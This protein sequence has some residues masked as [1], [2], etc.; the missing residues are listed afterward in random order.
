M[1]DQSITETSTWQH[2][3]FTT[4]KHPCPR[5]DS[6]PQS[7][8]ASGHWD[9]LLLL[10]RNIKYSC[11]KSLLITVFVSGPGQPN[12]SDEKRELRVI[13]ERVPPQ[14][15]T[16]VSVLCLYAWNRKLWMCISEQLIC[17][18]LHHKIDIS[19]HLFNVIAPSFH[20]V[21]Y[22]ICNIFSYQS[23]DMSCVVV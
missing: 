20:L 23:F 17:G 6:N 14:K 11:I 22:F 16:L 12:M 15:G 3:T 21:F 9:Q 5:W 10:C 1:S 13:L 4:D 7:Q 2:A 18:A 19:L 8:Q